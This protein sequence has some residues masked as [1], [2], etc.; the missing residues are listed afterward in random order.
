[1]ISISQKNSIEGLAEQR[2]SGHLL[3]LFLVLSSL[4]AQQGVCDDVVEGAYGLVL[5][6]GHRVLDGALSQ[7]LRRLRPAEVAPRRGFWSSQLIDLALVVKPATLWAPP[8][9]PPWCGFSCWR[10]QRDTCV[11]ISISQKNSIEGLA[12]QRLSG[13]LLL[14]F[15]VLSSL[16]AQ[17]GVCDDVVEGAYGLV[18]HGGH[19]VLDGALS[20]RLS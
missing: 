9:R 1:M 16:R 13:H 10:R 18:L 5:H 4:R 6:G 15:L 12:E 20:Q 14:L 17:Q 19:R 11:M 3:L 7:R 8:L 2:L